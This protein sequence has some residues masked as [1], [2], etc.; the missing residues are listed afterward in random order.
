MQTRSKSAIK[1]LELD[2]PFI[3]QN[4]PLRGC[5]VRSNSPSLTQRRR[6][7][8]A[9]TFKTV[10][11]EDIETLICV[12]SKTPSVLYH[13][14]RLRKASRSSQVATHIRRDS[15]LKALPERKYAYAQRQQRNPLLTYDSI[16]D[17]YCYLTP[18]EE[19]EEPK[20]TFIAHKPLKQPT[21]RL[22]RRSTPVGCNSIFY[23]TKALQSTKSLGELRLRISKSRLFNQC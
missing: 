14:P 2:L 15:S 7:R 21:G 23:K 6:L 16:R 17:T 13:T 20:P 22:V 18:Y 9:S 10:D 3:K 12:R 19:K 4:K 8:Q 5:L 1:L 11:L